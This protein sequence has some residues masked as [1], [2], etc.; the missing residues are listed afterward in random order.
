M[1][2]CVHMS[3]TK[4]GG[5]GMHDR[6]NIHITQCPRVEKKRDTYAPA[7]LFLY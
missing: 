7:Y 2:Q 1:R 3:E 4:R 5:R 6:G